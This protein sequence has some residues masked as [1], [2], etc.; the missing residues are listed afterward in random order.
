MRGREQAQAAEVT[1]SW[2]RYAV[3][4]MLVSVQLFVPPAE[5]E[6]YENRASD[7]LSGR[8]PEKPG[9]VA[10]A[11]ELAVCVVGGDE[12]TARYRPALPGRGEGR[13][14]VSGWRSQ[15]TRA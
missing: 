2:L 8:D 12:A 4:S 3:A 7:E 13:A 9:R 11:A 5:G 10:I 1:S 14:H 15:F 6:G